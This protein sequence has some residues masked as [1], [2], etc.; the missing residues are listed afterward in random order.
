MLKLAD[1]YYLD[2]DVKLPLDLTTLS[3]PNR[4]DAHCASR[5]LGA[6]A[7]FGQP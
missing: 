2:V 7:Q 3:E 5:S 1:S 4:R 6:H